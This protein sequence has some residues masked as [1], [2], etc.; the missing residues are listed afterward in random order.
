MR[1][2]A[3][4]ASSIV[5]FAATCST[6][7]PSA[8]APPGRD[9]TC[10][11]AACSSGCEP[12][13]RSSGLGQPKST[14]ARICPTASW[15][16]TRPLAIAWSSQRR[17]RS[18]AAAKCSASSSETCPERNGGRGAGERGGSPCPR[19]NAEAAGAGIALNRTR[20][21]RIGR[22]IPHAD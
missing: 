22:C 7:S 2:T 12:R 16:P 19:L 4:I 8:S 5:L 1:D 21:K 17:I 3:A 18:S 15:R 14:L 9:V 20:Q 10:L 13:M 11:S 6:G